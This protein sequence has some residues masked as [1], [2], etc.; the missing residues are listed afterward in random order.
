[1]SVIVSRL[2]SKE[3]TMKERIRELEINGRKYAYA[4]AAVTGE[5]RYFI[6]LLK[7]T[8]WVTFCSA[9]GY[10]YKSLEAAGRAFDNR[11]FFA[12]H[13]EGDDDEPRIVVSLNYLSALQKFR[14]FTK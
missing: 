12:E 7:K 4:A 14:Q 6:L 2:I 5:Q 11:L 1:M 13:Y 3:Q 9:N 10:G 8:R